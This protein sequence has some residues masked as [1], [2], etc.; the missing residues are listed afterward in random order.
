MGDAGGGNIG[1][2]ILAPIA[3]IILVVIVSI[4]CAGCNIVKWVQLQCC[5][6]LRSVKGHKRKRSENSTE[7]TGTEAGF[8]LEGKFLLRLTHGSNQSL[9]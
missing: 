2:L 1:F 3:F 5:I 8:D 9:C 6:K 7:S 4:K